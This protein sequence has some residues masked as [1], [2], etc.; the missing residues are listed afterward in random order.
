M[1]AVQVMYVCQVKCALVGMS[2][3]L[4][5]ELPVSKCPTALTHHPWKFSR[6]GYLG[7]AFN[8][9]MSYQQTF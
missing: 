2:S 3:T 4:F 6:F 7:T 8:K 1:A 5:N 9:I